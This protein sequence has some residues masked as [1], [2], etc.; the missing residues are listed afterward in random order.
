P[1]RN[2]SA[3]ERVSVH[4]SDFKVETDLLPLFNVFPEVKHLSPV[5]ESWRASVQSGG[6]E[7]K[8]EVQVLGVAPEYLR[9]SN[10]GLEPGS[11]SLNRFHLKD[12]SAVCLI[13]KEI[14]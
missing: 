3:A 5:L 13:G 1:N 14:A 11:R 6:I 8:D 10:R 2:T 9:I 7:I 4:F 12:R